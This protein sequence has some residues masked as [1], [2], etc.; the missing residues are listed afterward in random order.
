MIGLTIVFVVL[1]WSVAILLHFL[2]RA[3]LTTLKRVVKIAAWLISS[4][5]IALVVMAIAATFF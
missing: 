4:A 2:K 1:T 5:F 3:N